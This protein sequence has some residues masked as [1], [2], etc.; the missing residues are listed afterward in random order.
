MRVNG[1]EMYL[2]R[3][4]T[5]ALAIMQASAMANSITWKL[6][7][8]SGFSRAHQAIREQRA[9]LLEELTKIAEI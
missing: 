5:H 4:K 9:S 2:L 3:V 6:A 1:T 7:S 8:H